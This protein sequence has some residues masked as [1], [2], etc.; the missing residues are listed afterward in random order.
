MSSKT[1]ASILLFAKFYYFACKGPQ[2]LPPPP[3][4]C[5]SRPH[6]CQAF[7]CPIIRSAKLNTIN[8][9]FKLMIS[10]FTFSMTPMKTIDYCQ[11]ILYMPDSRL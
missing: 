3:V 8:W 6:Q 10:T 9:Q 7:D 2:V 11:G 5:F 4:T 1:A